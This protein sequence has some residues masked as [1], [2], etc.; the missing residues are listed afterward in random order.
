MLNSF[1]IRGRTARSRPAVPGLPLIGYMYSAVGVTAATGCFWLVHAYVD[2]GQAS[3]LYLPIVIA[4]A[5]RFGF[6]PAVLAAILSFLCWDYFFFLP[7]FTLTVSNPKDW[8]SL[9]VFL[10]AAVTTAQLAAQ[11]RLQ[12]AQAQAREAEIATLFEASQALSQEVSAARLLYVLAQQLRT[13]CHATHC[14][15][16]RLS[17]LDAALQ[18]VG[19]QEAA[20]PVPEREQKAIQEAAERAF[21]AYRSAGPPLSTDPHSPGIFAPL[22]AAESLIGILYVGPRE[23]SRP[24]SAIDEHLILT[25]ANHAAT[26]IARETLAEQASQ[27]VALRETDAL[28][29]ALLSLVSHELRTPLAAIKA[30]ASGLLQT[31]AYWDEESRREAL[32]AIDREAD[33]LTGLVNHLLDLS[34]LEAGAWHPSKDWCDLPEIIATVLDRLPEATAARVTVEAPA[35]LPLVRVDYIQI[36]L[37]I[38]NLIENAAKYAPGDS[39]IQIDAGPAD[40]SLNSLGSD[41][42]VLVRVRDFGAGIMQCEEESLFTRFFRG[43]RH[44]SSLIHGTGLGLALCEAVIRAHSGRIWAA[45]APLSEPCGAVFSFFLPVDLENH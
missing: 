41:S 2:K 35:D 13:L 5:I 12:T 42:R 8:L 17:P 45:N 25:L 19:G 34:R 3:L 37:V 32:S 31:D 11:A 33:R 9:V 38:Q 26:V 20:S 7:A 1:T 40:S 15:V 4:C 30:S 44:R 14:L 18:I 21:E 10:V 29:D 22:Y 23:D 27:A 43:S 24:F 39:P 6:G 16:F 36:A 28:K